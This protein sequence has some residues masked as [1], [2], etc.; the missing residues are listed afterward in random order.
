MSKKYA[1]NI[2]KQLIDIVNSSAND[3]KCGECGT[4]Y[5][6]WASYNLGIFLC[7]R[8]S[9]VHKRILGPPNYNISKV[10]SLTLDNWSDEQISH[11]RKIGN[12][13]AKRKWNSKRVPFPFDGDDNISVVEQYIRDKYI[14]GK[15]RDDNIEND[16]YETD[17]LSKYSND[18]RS[19]SRSRSNSNFGAGAIPKLTHRKLTTYEYTQ[20]QTQVNK[21]KS[22][23]FT[24]YDAI[25][26][27]LLLSNGVIDKAIDILEQDQRI[28]PTKE[29]TAP[30]L[31]K[32]RPQTQSQSTSSSNLLDPKPSGDWWNS[33]GINNAQATQSQQFPAQTGQPQIYQYTDPITGA[34]L[35]VD[36]S[37]QEYLDPNNPQHQ[38]QLYNMQNPQLIQQQTNKANIM[39]LYNQP[40][41]QQQLSPQRAQ[42]APQIPQQTTAAQFGFQQQ[43]QQTGFP[44]Q[45]QQQPQ[46]TGFGQPQQQQ[47]QQQYP[48]QQGYYR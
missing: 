39:S 15:F 44:M 11:L 32:R 24:D 28:N 23:G 31:P 30:E 43:P 1:K 25:L 7:G 29:E 40:T 4:K 5:P 41:N 2:E 36:S 19:R 46:F 33:N 34:I 9:S 35:Y 3:N 8:C 12:K 6:T 42:S 17:R 48:N 20:Y 16:D 21:I 14:L 27:S 22:L 10:K 26:E 38:Q 18:S 45:Q 47:F 37:G 13:K